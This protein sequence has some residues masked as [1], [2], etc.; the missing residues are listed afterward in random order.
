MKNLVRRSSLFIAFISIFAVGVL[1]AAA[2]SDDAITE[3]RGIMA[4]QTAAWNRGDIDG[5][6]E[7]YARS[8]T[9]VCFRRT[10]HPWLANRPR[11]LQEKIR[12]PGEDGHADIFEC[13]SHE[14]EFRC[15]PGSW[16]LEVGPEKRPAAR[17]FHLAFSP[18][19]CRLAHRPRSHL[20]TAARINLESRK[21]GD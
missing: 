18:H 13:P 7:G 17:D 8:S 4:K 16:P 15:C 5:F 3:I 21:P 14:A 10:A 19:A 20:L 9:T 2:K 1:S 6:M 12:Q 11:S